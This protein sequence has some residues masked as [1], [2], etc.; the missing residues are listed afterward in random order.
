[1]YLELIRDIIFNYLIIYLLVCIGNNY[2]FI[3]INY[4]TCFILYLFSIIFRA[5]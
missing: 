1:M 2:L 3:R 5:I 4:S